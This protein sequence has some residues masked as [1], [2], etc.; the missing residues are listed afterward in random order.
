MSV[1]VSKYTCITSAIPTHKISEMHLG[2]RDLRD[3]NQ[4]A[5]ETLQE[6]L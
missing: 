1:P 6:T 3:F 5:F 4:T 2:L